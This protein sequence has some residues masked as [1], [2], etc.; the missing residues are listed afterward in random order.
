MNKNKNIL[1]YALLVIGLAFVITSSCK[2][3]KEETVAPSIP[4]PVINTFG[5]IKIKLNTAI[6][7][8][9]ITSDG[10]SLVTARGICWNTSPVP[11]ITNNKTIEGD[12]AGV[13][14]SKMTG[15]TAKTK[16]YVRAYATN[17]GGTSYGS[18]IT[19]TTLDSTMTDIEGNIYRTIQIGDQ[20]WMAENLRTTTYRD[21]VPIPE[22]TDNTQW[23][24]LTTGA[25]C[26]YN[27]D[28]SNVAVYGRLYNY[29][30]ISS[31]RNLAPE[32]WHIPS[33]HEWVVLYKYLGGDNIAGGKMKETGTAHWTSPNTGA[34][35]ESRFT[36]LPGGGRNNSFSNINSIGICGSSTEY[37]STA[38]L[39]AVILYSS[40]S[41]YVEAG[42]KDLGVSIRCVMD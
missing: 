37:N 34:T 38:F 3:D 7:S 21:E 29:Y 17:S 9:E 20:V 23:D 13:F 26:N 30:A 5:M 42:V 27:N 24:N 32:G 18:T 31:S 41:S 14:T 40:A 22:V 6:C 10:G 12:G 33:F 1:V 15:L 25:Y 8:A 19:F 4:M 11:T 39:V 35:N 36:A 2:K 28:I 16:Y